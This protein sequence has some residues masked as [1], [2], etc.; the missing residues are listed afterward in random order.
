MPIY[1]TK[2]VPQYIHSCTFE[3]YPTVGEFQR[4]EA[5]RE[6]GEHLA[7]GFH[8]LVIKTVVGEIEVRE[9]GLWVG[10]HGS[11]QP[12]CHISDRWTEGGETEQERKEQVKQEKENKGG[13]RERERRA[14]GYQER[15]NANNELKTELE[16]TAIGE[17]MH[18]PMQLFPHTLKRYW[19]IFSTSTSAIYIHIQDGVRMHMFVYLFSPALLST[20]VLKP[21]LRGFCSTLVSALVTS[22]E[23]SLSFCCTPSKY[24]L[25]PRADTSGRSNLDKGKGGEGGWMCRGK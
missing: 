6:G 12:Q 10:L 20:R 22:G 21:F 25:C 8:A 4:G 11:K 14:F 17:R 13:K 2:G 19:T 7:K 16:E 23:S 9:A 5:V 15:R 1:V 3:S 24:S 18:V